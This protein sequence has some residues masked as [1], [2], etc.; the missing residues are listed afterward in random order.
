VKS[1]SDLLSEKKDVYNA[2]I[3]GMLTNQGNMPV[4]RILMMMRMMV[5]GGFPFGADE[6]KA[7]LQEMEDGGKVVGLGGDVWAMKK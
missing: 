1:Q 2:F 4:A 6:V 3:M 5:Q 7:L